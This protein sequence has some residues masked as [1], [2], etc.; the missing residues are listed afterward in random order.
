VLSNIKDVFEL[1]VFNVVP[2]MAILM[3]K[4]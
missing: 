4:I 3:L 1:I 2:C